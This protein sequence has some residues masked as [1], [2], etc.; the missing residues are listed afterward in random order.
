M[1]GAPQTYTSYL[2]YLQLKDFCSKPA[3]ITN[4]NCKEYIKP[5]KEIMKEYLKMI[6][7]ENM[8]Y[9]KNIIY[10]DHQLSDMAEDLT[11]RYNL[12]NFMSMLVMLFANIAII[13]DVYNNILELDYMMITP[14]DYTLMIKYAPLHIDKDLV[15]KALQIVTTP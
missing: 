6:S 5:D 15:K 13:V 10:Q 9:Y 8:H 11:V 4:I 2:Y 7:F 3:H 1:V 12:L 14:S